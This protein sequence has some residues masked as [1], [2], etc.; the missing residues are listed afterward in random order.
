[1]LSLKS[2][3][4]GQSVVVQACNPSYL[5]EKSGGLPEAGPGQNVLSEALSEK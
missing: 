2:K 1:M 5:E 3:V 4:Q